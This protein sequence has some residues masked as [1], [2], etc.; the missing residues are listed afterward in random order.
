VQRW[1][2]APVLTL[3]C[4]VAACSTSSPS[5]PG[6]PPGAESRETA[7]DGGPSGGGTAVDGAVDAPSGPPAIRFVGRFDAR[8]TKG[9][10]CGW[11]GCRVIARFEGTAVSAKLEEIL[12]EWQEE[13]GPSEWDVAID[14]AVTKKIVVQKGEQSFELAS[15][16]AAG[17]HT[18]ELYKRSEAQN[19]VTRF[20]AFDFHG[21]ALLSPP[22]APGRRIEIVGDSQP[23]AFGI[24]GVGEGP[25][26]PGNDWAARWQ[27]FHRS[28]GARLGEILGADV[29]GTVYSGKGFVRNIWRPDTEAMPVLYER[30]N[31]V[32]DP[33]PFDLASFVPDVVTIMLGG[34]DFAV[35]QP[36]D[37]GPTPE[38]QFLAAVDTFVGRLR[39]AYPAA[40]LYLVVSPSVSDAEP[41]GRGSRTKIVSAFMT[42]ATER[43]AKGDA[44]VH[45]VEP[46]VAQASELTACNGHGS[47][48]YHER[49]ARDLEPVI[50][51]HMGW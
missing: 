16:L 40:H 38:D 15:G 21:G 45:F 43:T 44:R 36:E 4:I 25:D 29:H 10:K 41:A 8:E 30:A 33:S 13:G 46:P 9:P 18:V 17:V 37:D 28:F 24:E 35:G 32:D 19:G 26:C 11:P 6:A 20:L 49:V 3:T 27:N 14:G 23:A 12:Y 51:G 48:A 47:P 50:R 2:F 5:G 22:H 31:P 1:I 39:G 42:V 7:G 34:N